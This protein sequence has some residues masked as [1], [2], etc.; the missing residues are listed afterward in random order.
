VPQ[1]RLRVF[2]TASKIGC[3]LPLP[4]IPTHKSTPKSPFLNELCGNLL[5]VPDYKDNLISA[6][7]AL[8]AISDLEP[9]E[10]DDARIKERKYFSSPKSPY[11]AKMREKSKTCKQHYGIK[12]FKRKKIFDNIHDPSEQ[13]IIKRARVSWNNPFRTICS[14]PTTRVHSIHPEV[15]RVLSVREYARAQSFPDHITFYGSVNSKYEQIGNSVPPILAKSVG[16][17]F[18]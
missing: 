11:Q 15:D 14:V 1:D 18:L 12:M 6:I 2:L 7:T 10:N 3:P 13:K 9:Y 4:P 16:M 5:V 17:S 8:G